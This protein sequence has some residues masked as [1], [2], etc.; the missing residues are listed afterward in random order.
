MAVALVFHQFLLAR[1]GGLVVYQRTDF[2]KVDVVVIPS[3]MS[4]ARVL[5]AADLMLDLR[6]ERAV[7]FREDLPQDFDELEKLGVDFTESHELNR[8]VL[9]KQGI[10]GSQVEV[11]PGS[12]DSTWMEAQAFR[13]YVDRHSLESIVITTSLYHSYRT[14]LNFEK[15]LE[16]TGVDIYSLPTPYGLFSPNGWWK[17]RDAAK[18]LYVEL[19]SLGAF[20]LGVR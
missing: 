9:L 1:I 4:P 8:E 5:G 16:G 7:L 18:L 15:A 14:Y 3:G 2:E 11:L 13:R 6:A 20:F 10:D 19:A 17:N 12:V